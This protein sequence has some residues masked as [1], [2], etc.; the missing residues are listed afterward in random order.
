MGGLEL[1]LNRCGISRI[2][3]MKQPRQ[4]E[5]TFH[6]AG[7]PMPLHFRSDH[8]TV[9]HP[10]EA[11]ERQAAVLVRMLDEVSA[12]HQRREQLLAQLAETLMQLDTIESSLRDSLPPDSTPLQRLDASRSA[13]AQL[14]QQV[15]ADTRDD[16]VRQDKALDRA[17]QSLAEL[18]D[19]AG[20]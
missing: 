10:S 6:F 18:A 7:H 9:R 8:D 13:L 5:T 14:A 20:T 11:H 12:T 19:P 16:H 3:W 15:A 4:C 1:P 17:H 2:A